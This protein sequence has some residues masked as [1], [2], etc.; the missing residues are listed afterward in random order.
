MPFVG[1]DS[2]VARGGGI[3]IPPNADFSGGATVTS[4]TAP[5][6]GTGSPRPS[7]PSVRRAPGRPVRSRASGGGIDT[8]GALTL[9]SAVSG[10]QVGGEA[11]DAEGGGIYGRRRV[12]N[13]QH[14][15]RGNRAAATVPNGRFADS[16]GIFVEGGS[17]TMDSTLVDNN[18]V[19][20]S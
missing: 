17:L 1:A 12:T 6:R 19:L 15:D 13:Q 11:S 10:N 8:W 4:A 2:V 16:G 3:E 5:S 20:L 18:A 7:V 14:G 9:S